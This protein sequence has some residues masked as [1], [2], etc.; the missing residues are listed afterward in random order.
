MTSK[1]T[2]DT[3]TSVFE[4]MMKLSDDQFRAKLDQVQ[5]HPLV[6]MFTTHDDSIDD[7]VAQYDKDVG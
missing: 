2:N 3:Y 4:N 5:H 1:L 6:T 7:L